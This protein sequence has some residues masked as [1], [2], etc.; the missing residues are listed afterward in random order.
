MTKR[1]IVTFKDDAPKS[2]V[3]K[4]IADLEAAGGKVTHRYD[5]G[6]L[7]GFAAE[8]PD[9]HMQSLQQSSLQPGSQIEAIEPDGVATIQ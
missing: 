8:I 6:V 3:D 5:G 2:E 4:A 9:V 1:Y 7:N